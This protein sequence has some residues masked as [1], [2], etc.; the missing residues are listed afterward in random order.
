M[1]YGNGKVFLEN[2]N[3]VWYNCSSLLMLLCT[4]MKFGSK[5]ECSIFSHQ[6]PVYTF[7]LHIQ[8]L[9]ISKRRLH[10]FLHLGNLNYTLSD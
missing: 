8:L 3:G 5:S 7:L 6:L 10:K 4:G 9:K 2:L 1:V